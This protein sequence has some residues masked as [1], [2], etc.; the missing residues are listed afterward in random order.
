MKRN[1][2][3]VTYFNRPVTLLCDIIRVGQSA[4][5]FEITKDLGTTVRLCDFNGKTKVISV[6][7]TLDTSMGLLQTQAMLELTRRLPQV[8]L[9]SIS[10]DLP[11]VVRKFSENNS[12]GEAIILSDYINTDFCLKYGLLIEELRLPARSIIII[13]EN[14]IIRYVNTAKELCS[15]PDYEQAEN[16]LRQY[17]SSREG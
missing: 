1:Y 9:I 14:N 10:C 12:M 7:P 17:L 3:Y 15:H 2:G 6:L 11:H 4:P 13:D 8:Q 5:D 16:F